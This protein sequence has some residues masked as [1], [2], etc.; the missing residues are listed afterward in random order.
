[1]P[2]PWTHSPPDAP[3][4]GGSPALSGGQLPLPQLQAHRGAQ[5]SHHLPSQ[6]AWDGGWQRLSSA[7][8]TENT[9]CGLGSMSLRQAEQW[10]PPWRGHLHCGRGRAHPMPHS[11]PGQAV[12]SSQERAATSLR[13]HTHSRPAGGPEREEGGPAQPVET[14]PPHLHSTL[15]S[16]QHSPQTPDWMVPV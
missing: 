6:L 2:Q 4:R 3:S 11:R 13:P 5:A 14:W 10:G 8:T 16:D 1:M 7:A 12:P 15:P 9:G